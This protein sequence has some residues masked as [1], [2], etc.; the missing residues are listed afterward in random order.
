MASG[1]AAGAGAAA[2]TGAR[3]EESKGAA[4]TPRLCYNMV[5]GYVADEEDV[6]GSLRDADLTVGVRVFRSGDNQPRDLVHDFDRHAGLV[7]AWMRDDLV[8]ADSAFRY[9]AGGLRT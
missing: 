3:P 5:R 4:E 1:D 7:R 2:I 6:T 9:G 8:A